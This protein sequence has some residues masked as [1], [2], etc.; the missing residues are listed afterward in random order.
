MEDI[1]DKLTR[2][3]SDDL[4]ESAILMIQEACI[5]YARKMLGVSSTLP[6]DEIRCL[7]AVLGISVIRR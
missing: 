3:L 6:L 1:C 7:Q 4:A 2:I 5:T